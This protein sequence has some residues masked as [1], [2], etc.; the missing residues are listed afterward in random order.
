MNMAT[1]TMINRLGGLQPRDTVGTVLARNRGVGPSFDHLRLLL[2]TLILVGHA[3]WAS[4]TPSIDSLLA[5]THP[6]IRVAT[7]GVAAA[8]F[9]GVVKAIDRGLVPSFF[10]LSGFLV[11]GSALRLRATSTFLAH[12]ALRI[13][14]ALSVEVT[15]SALILGPLLTKLQ[16]H[17]YFADSEFPKYFGNM[18]GQITY[19]L[20]G[21]FEDNPVPQNRQ[22]EPVDFAGR[23]Q[24]LSSRR[25][26]ALDKNYLQQVSVCDRIHRCDHGSRG[27]Q[28]FYRNFFSWSVV[29]TAWGGDCIFLSALC[30]IISRIEY[31]PISDSS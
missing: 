4:M 15:L 3:H 13:F 21:V 10:A 11:L 1:K 7:A 8:H 29:S 16:L 26:A 2:A 22:H 18:V 12:R 27:S 24:L 6:T 30:F 9:V 28:F 19:V 17:D 23:V 31:P 14:P 5:T 20:P 25:R